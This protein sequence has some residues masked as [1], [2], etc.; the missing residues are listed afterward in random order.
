MGDALLDPRLICG[1][2]SFS[3]SVAKLQWPNTI[4]PLSKSA[5]VT[6]LSLTYTSYI[7]AAFTFEDPNPNSQNPHREKTVCK[8]FWDER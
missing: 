1:E 3:R 8:M 5:T 4:C 6:L 7:Y 2:E